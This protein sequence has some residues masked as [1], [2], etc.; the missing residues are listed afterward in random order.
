MTFILLSILSLVSTSEWQLST[1]AMIF[2]L[3]PSFFCHALN[4]RPFLL[5]LF[6]FLQLTSICC[7]TVRV[8]NLTGISLT[9]ALTL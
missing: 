2:R 5:A 7:A 3:I 1:Y 9:S 6:L 4:T 8:S